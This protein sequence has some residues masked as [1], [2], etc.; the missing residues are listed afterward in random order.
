YENGDLRS[1]KLGDQE[2]LRRIYVAVRDR[3]WSTVPNLIAHVQMVVDS[4]AFQITYTVENHQGDIDFR[5]RGAIQGDCAGTLTFQMDGEA[6]STF[7]RNRIGFCVLHP[8]HCAGVVA[9]ITYTD[10]QME[11]SAFPVAIA[12]QLVVNGEIKPVSPFNEM[13]AVA[14]EVTPDLWAE[15]RFSGDIFEMEDQRNWTDASYKTY[16]TPLRL[17]F[18]AEIQQGTKITQ[19]ITL[20]LIGEGKTSL[21]AAL[22]TAAPQTIPFQRKLSAVSQ[23]VPQLGLGVAS[24]GQALSPLE[25]ERLRQLKLT[26]LRVDLKLAQPDYTAVLQQ[27]TMEA[28][29]LQVTLEIALHL[30]NAATELPALAKLIEALRPPVGRWLIFQ[31]GEPVTAASW[32]QMARE[33]LA[34]YAADVPIGGVT[35]VYFTDLNRN[36]PAV[37][38]LDLVAYSLNPQVHAFDN[39]SLIETLAAQAAT[40]TSARQLI[41]DLPLVISPVTLQPRFNPNATAPESTPLPNTLPSSVDPR[42]MALFGAGWTLGSLKYLAESGAASITYYETTGWRGVMEIATGSTAPEKFRS[43]PG[44]VFPLYH[45]LA[46]VGEFAGGEVLPTI[47]G[48][49]LRLDGLLLRKAGQTRLLLANLTNQPQQVTV[50]DLGEQ[51]HVQFLDETNAEA[52]MSAPETFRTQAGEPKSSLNGELTL[53]LRPYAVVRIDSGEINESRPA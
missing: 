35:N 20:T 16:S 11:M 26:H 32:V 46:A 44:A 36:R 33:W 37:Q 2:I 40:V 3:N 45:V 53:P 19:A 48:D 17:P 6:H 14:H 12:P 8:M 28:R 47:S 51:V 10:G 18:P 42:Q 15:V 39:Q 38:A 5:W 1:I 25:L 30:T 13:Q 22:P 31:E 49:P 29:A 4:D 27:A 21:P 41:G 34:D 7:L 24:H 52:A 9:R 23:P 43:L 50:Q